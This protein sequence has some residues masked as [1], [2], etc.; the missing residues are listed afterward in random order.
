V[1]TGEDLKQTTKIEAQAEIIPYFQVQLHSGSTLH[2]GHWLQFNLARID[3][4][5]DKGDKRLKMTLSLERPIVYPP[6]ARAIINYID[7]ERL[8]VAGTLPLP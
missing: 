5:E 1:L 6:G 3:T 2:L 4:V 7:G 8:R